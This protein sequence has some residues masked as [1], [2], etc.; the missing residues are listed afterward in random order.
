MKQLSFILILIALVQC[1]W[2]QTNGSA[3]PDVVRTIEHPDFTSLFTYDI[4]I[5]KVEFGEE[6]TTLY[7]D[8]SHY[9]GTSFSFRS[10][11]YLVDEEGRRY[12]IKS[13]KGFQLDKGYNVKEDGVKEI[14]ISFEPLPEG[15]RVFDC[16]E[17]PDLQWSF[18]FYG[19]REK[20]LVRKGRTGM[21]FPRRKWLTIPSQRVSSVWILSM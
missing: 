5:P 19:I 13:C 9:T 21:S 17:G 3:S 1:T 10:S 4:E 16:I 12:P 14:S 18:Q 6:Q 11:T 2:A 20:G 8:F 7:F 15:T